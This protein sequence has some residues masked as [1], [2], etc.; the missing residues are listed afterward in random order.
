MI[1]HDLDVCTGN[2]SL[3]EIADNY[4]TGKWISFAKWLQRL[5]QEKKWTKQ[6]K[7]NAKAYLSGLLMTQGCLQGFLVCDIR[8]LI[9][10]IIEQK[11]EKPHLEEI[12]MEMIEWLEE[13]QEIGAEAVILDGQ[14]RLKFAIVPFIYGG[15]AI[16]LTIDGVEKNLSLI[17]I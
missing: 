7:A 15:L 11:S 3:R 13:K 5:E 1:N 8:F 9:R 12:W 2:K 17:H 16:P 14:N 10:D 4:K 6:D